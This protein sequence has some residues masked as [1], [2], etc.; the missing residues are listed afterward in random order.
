MKPDPQIPERLDRLTPSIFFTPL[1]III[2]VILFFT[3]L[4]YRQADLALFTVL[5]LITPLILKT[6][7]IF[8]TRRLTSRFQMDR[9]RL[10]PGENADLN[11]RIENKKLLPVFCKIRLKINDFL[12]P[13]DRHESKKEEIV[14]LWH[15]GVTFHRELVAQKRGVYRIDSPFLTAGDVF[16]FYPRGRETDTRIEVIVYPRIV[17][18]R[19][20]PLLKRIIFG[21][22]GS[23]GPVHD[24]AYILGTRDYLHF[25]PARYIHWKASARHHRLQEKLLEPAEQNK[26]MFILDVGEFKEENAHEDF[27]RAIEVLA[28]LA[29]ELDSQKYAIGFITNGLPAH[30]V[31]PL[32]PTVR[33]PGQI[34]ALLE[35]LAH[36][37][38]RPMFA[39]ENFF[40][41]N[42]KLPADAIGIYFSYRASPD[43][44]Y[45]NQR[46]IP[47]V[48]VTCRREPK[49]A[50]V[51]SVARR[52]IH[53]EAVCVPEGLP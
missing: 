13:H 5:L 6:W 14:L 12:L 49:D 15:Q 30:A 46:H 53:L 26:V 18:I 22:P 34:T 24:P 21:K 32:L 27:E 10:F 39:M 51:G 43:I 8:S 33:K 17:P 7:S 44:R 29:V 3:A 20:F 50:P 48:N 28:S 40:K 35:S 19:P 4:V 31:T 9:D 37:Q 23:T 38:N 1:F 42:A 16:G 36:T 52:L 25:R 47:A 41:Q 11:I 45:L 2:N